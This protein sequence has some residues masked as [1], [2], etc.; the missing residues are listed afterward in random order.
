M[1]RVSVA[2]VV[3]EIENEE[4]VAVGGLAVTGPCNLVCNENSSRAIWTKNRARSDFDFFSLN[5]QQLTR[6]PLQGKYS[7]IFNFYVAAWKN[8]TAKFFVL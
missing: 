6:I 2:V 8:H 4:V 5:R 3:I 7:R 1:R